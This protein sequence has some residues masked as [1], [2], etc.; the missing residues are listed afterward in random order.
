MPKVTVT[1]LGKT[2]DVKAGESLLDMALNHDIP[3]M[4]ACG[5]FCACTTCHV[6]VKEGARNLDEM[7]GD[8]SDR[9]E[10]V[11]G[12]TPTSRLACQAKVRG[13]VTIEIMKFE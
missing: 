1:N 2:F 6:V 4:H 3:I 10:R 13:D 11:S 12:L 5:G 9:I 8:E 7:E